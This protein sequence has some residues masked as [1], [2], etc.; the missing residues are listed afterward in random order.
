[1]EDSK[2]PNA[3]VLGAEAAAL[4]VTFLRI[5]E[6]T[7]LAVL[8]NEFWAKQAAATFEHHGPAL[9]AL[10]TGTK[11][12]ASVKP[13]T[14]DEQLCA[15]WEELR[16]KNNHFT[17]P[18]MTEVLSMPALRNLK[19]QLL[20]IASRVL[21]EKKRG[22]PVKDIGFNLRFEGNPG[23]GKTTVAVL[24]SK[25]L[26]DLGVIQGDEKA[27]A[28]ARIEKEKKERKAQQ[29][30][31]EK[32]QKL[33]EQQERIQQ[34]VVNTM[35]GRGGY[36]GNGPVA[37]RVPPMPTVPVPPMT[38]SK[39]DDSDD[40][41]DK[42]PPKSFVE[43]SGA[44][45][46]DG[47]VELLKEQLEQIHKAGGGV[48][49]VDEAYMLEPDKSQPGKQVLNLL[50]AEM[51]KRRG[52]LIVVFAGYK[53]KME[54]LFQYNE[55]L[56]SRFS[57]TIAFEDYDDEQLFNIFVNIM[58]KKPGAQVMKFENDDPHWCRVAIRR[59]GA[60]R[61]SPGFGN[62]R[63]CRN[64]FDTV[65]NR[66]AARCQRE[67]SSN[68]FTLIKEDFL[69]PSPADAAKNS[70]AWTELKAMIGL[71]KVKKSVEALFE[72]VKTN[73]LLELEM[74]PRQPVALNRLFLGNPGTGKTTVAKIYAE[75]LR[76]FGLLSKGDVIMKAASDFIGSVLGESQK[77]ASAIIKSA[78]GSVLVIDEAYGLHGKDPYK[79]SVID[80][81]V[82]QVQGV[83]GEDKA[84]VL[85]GYR[86]QMEIMLREAN[87]G[88]QRRFQLENAFQFDDYND[89]ELNQILKFKMG[90]M[91]LEADA[92]ALSAAIKYLGVQR[93]TKPPFGNG[94]AVAN[95]LS[96][97]VNRK[98]ARGAGTSPILIE[99]DFAP[100]D[101][102]AKYDTDEKVLFKGLI[103]CDEIV[104]K[105]LEFKA[106]FK[107]AQ[108][109]GQDP[110]KKLSLNFRFVGAPGTGKTTVAKRM[111]RMFRGL[112]VLPSADVVETSGTDLVGQFVGQ[113][114]PKTRELMDKGLGKVLFIDE[115]YTLASN[116]GGFAKEAVDELVRCLTHEK[117]MGKMV[118]ILAGY[119]H[120]IERLM[121]VNDGLRS[122]FAEV[123][124]F[125][126]FNADE[127]CKLLHMRLAEP[128]VDLM[129]SDEVIK[130]GTI[131]KQMARLSAHPKFSNGRDIVNWAK[132][133]ER[134]VA[135][136]STTADS[137]SD[138][139]LIEHLEK[140]MDALLSS[141]GPAS[142]PVAK[143]NTSPTSAPPVMFQDA[144]PPPQDNFKIEQSTKIE[145][146][147]EPAKKPSPKVKKERTVES[148][149]FGMDVQTELLPLNTVVE[150]ELDLAPE[151]IQELAKASVNDSTARQAIELLSKKVGNMNKATQ[152]FQKWQSAQKQAIKQAEQEKEDMEAEMKMLNQ[153][154]T[155]RPIV[156]CQVCKATA[157]YWA[158]CWVAPMVIG[159]NQYPLNE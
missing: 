54:D 11:P 73:E 99:S 123:I 39:Q 12:T 108:D 134:E 59:L 86:E 35:M 21:F 91:G 119:E 41:D 77:T 129:L 3:T 118:V 146:A 30:R 131:E 97:A 147:A 17:S 45:L 88:L 49:F 114:A 151:Q 10:I 5:P 46:V 142:A 48:L 25:L 61:G 50:L 121:Q 143:P 71:E 15:E 1:M 65:C 75:I 47:G 60:G 14:E 18:A 80:T 74:K 93:D 126:N 36:G 6:P 124:H 133:I 8:P 83:P 78:E 102:G 127:S 152:I 57:H 42:K 4:A 43:T 38:S 105:L 103:G 85:L 76:D 138:M 58:R 139:V 112:G 44:E 116:S 72:V 64:L 84:V 66:Q 52:S 149:Y 9:K 69:G 87:P 157:E 141:L 159:W 2:A 111:G 62:A 110:L 130:A 23:T 26:A 40:D 63:S 51:E 125:R 81:I 29:E 79:T 154:M 104:K 32:A 7:R 113:S 144:A 120:D 22:S 132:R 56:P 53:K 27:A 67:S 101:E 148:G 37:S 24:Y 98:A 28:I 109:K 145:E 55:G 115:A 128:D 136:G 82:E 96:E 106:T 95:L 34:Q 135:M 156:Q 94:G 70:K 19:R 92:D 117:Y 20:N 89:N 100:V 140:T 153:M 16:A 137:N 155:I 107:R 13:P 122:R 33:R 150:F 31:E 68:Y 158:A 90:K